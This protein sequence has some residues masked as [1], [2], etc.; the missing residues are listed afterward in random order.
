VNLFRGQ[1]RDLGYSRVFGGQVLCQAVLAASA[2]VEDRLMHSLH[3]YFLRAGDPFAPIVYDV[4]RN[5]DGRSFTARRVVAIQHGQPI[6]TMSASFQV[7]EDGLE[8]QFAAPEVPDPDEIGPP[9]PLAADGL[10]TLPGN[11]R[12]WINRF[13]PFE[14]RR[15]G[16]YDAVNPQPQR[17]C[18]QIWFRLH[19]D[20]PEDPVLHRALLAYVSDFHLVGTATLAHGISPLDD[21]LVMASL[22]HAMWFHRDCRLDDWLLY[23]C[24]SPSTSAGRGLSRG[25]IYNRAGTL[26]ASTAQEGVVR[27]RKENKRKEKE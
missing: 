12:C 9:E 26:I 3:A 2:T 25:M 24:D 27:V 13:G 1:S 20:L 23:A 15:V 14:F 7:R 10:S 6:F 18:Q 4:D 11:I 17:P 22:D 5:R 19:G 8:H 16:S 21:K